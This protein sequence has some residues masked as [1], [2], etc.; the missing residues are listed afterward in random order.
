MK[1]A[2]WWMVA[3][4]AV[5]LGCPASEDTPSGGDEGPA[6]DEGNDTEASAGSAESTMGGSDPTMTS[7]SGNDNGGS[8]DPS[9]PQDSGEDEGQSFVVPPDGGS[10]NECDPK[11]QDCPDGQK[12]T[13]WANDGGT[14]WNANRCVAITGENVAGDPCMVEGSGV[15]GVDDCGLGNICMYTNEENF[16][17]CI[18]FCQGENEDCDPG[19]VCAIYNDGVL[20]ICLVSCDP[21]IQNCPELQACIDTPNGAFI[22]FTD[23]SGEAGM[24]G[25]PCPEEHGENSC[26]PGMWC[27][28]G[29]SGCD[30]VNCCTP[31]CDLGDGGCV[32]PNECLSFFGEGNAPPGYENVGVCIVPN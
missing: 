7:T 18:A 14:F 31:Y 24:A 30:A 1:P 27:G 8:S 5:A 22:C 16:G 17:T 28:A 6:D 12:C 26:D 4:V 19:S 10:A 25:D 15:S 23:A 3:V 29:T 20:P 32:A 13:A 21:L 9:G 2:R 11:A